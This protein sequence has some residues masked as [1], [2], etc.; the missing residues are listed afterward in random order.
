M[1]ADTTC[2]LRYS[3]VVT[4][5]LCGTEKIVGDQHSVVAGVETMVVT[6]PDGNEYHLAHLSGP[7]L[8]ND[9]VEQGK[10]WKHVH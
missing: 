6:A 10:R 3:P 4:T 2:R 5:G 1:H 8:L 9:F 7:E